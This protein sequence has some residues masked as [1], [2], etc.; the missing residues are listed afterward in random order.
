MPQYGEDDLMKRFGIGRAGERKGGSVPVD[1]LPGYVNRVG[2][3]LPYR[4]RASDPSI[5]TVS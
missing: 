2:H 3:C 5:V 4:E 1:A